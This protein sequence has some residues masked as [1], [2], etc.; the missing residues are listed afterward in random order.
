[1]SKSIAKKSIARKSAA[2]KKKPVVVVKK[3]KVNKTERIK[4]TRWADDSKVKMIGDNAHRI[5]TSTH[6]LFEAMKKAKTLGAARAVALKMMSAGRFAAF[7][8]LWIASKQ[9]SVAFAK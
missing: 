2:V 4:R 9:M 5:G 7:C 3:S 6:K 8:R 1:M